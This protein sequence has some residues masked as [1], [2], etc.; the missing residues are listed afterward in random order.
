MN[1]N[2]QKKKAVILTLLDELQENCEESLSKKSIKKDKYAFG[3]VSGE[4]EIIH[5]MK[6]FINVL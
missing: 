1:K 5:I 3:H 4:L 6:K 2:L